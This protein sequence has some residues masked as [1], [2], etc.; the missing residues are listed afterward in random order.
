[1]SCSNG[2]L[3]L[4][5]ILFHSVR[6]HCKLSKPLQIVNPQVIIKSV[7]IQEKMFIDLTNVFI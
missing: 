4:N 2:L 1:M 6:S 3:K 7:N 5:T